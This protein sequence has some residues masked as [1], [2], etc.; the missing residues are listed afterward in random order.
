MNLYCAPGEKLSI[1]IID[2]LASANAE[3]KKHGFTWYVHKLQTIFQLDKSAKE[4]ESWFKNEVTEEEK[5]FFA[6]FITGEGSINVSAKKERTSQFGLILDP[7][8]SVT[9]HVNGVSFLFLAFR[10][11]KT[12]SLRYKSG[13][14]ATLV[15]RIDSRETLKEKVIPFLNK[16]CT[17]YWNIIFRKRFLTFKKLL[18]AFQ[19]KK[20]LDQQSFVNQMLPLW[21]ELR[22][23]KTQSNASFSSL[24]EAQTYVNT[25]KKNK[26]DCKL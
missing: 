8:F 2:Q 4:V 11:F 3:R 26:K 10:T 1:N 7:E 21:D 14:N 16:Y 9:Q 24:E 5:F 13:S 22:K 25:Y 12:G 17:P 19:E 20:H 23:Q 15:Y 18:L 6:G